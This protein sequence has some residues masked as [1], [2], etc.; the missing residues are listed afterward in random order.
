MTATNDF[1][2]FAVGGSANVVSQ[3]AYAALSALLTNGFQSGIANSQQLNKVWRQSSIMAAVLGT[4][5]QQSGQ[6]ATDDGTTSALVTNLKAA[7]MGSKVS[8]NAVTGAVTLT[9]AN[10]GQTQVLTGSPAYSV[11]LPLAS[12][13]ASGTVLSFINVG[14]AN[15]T[16]QRQGTTDTIKP[17]ATG[18]TSIVLTPGDTLEVECDGSGTWYAFDG[19][20]VLPYAGVMSG[21]NWNTPSAG[22]NSTRLATTAFVSALVGGTSAASSSISAN[23]YQKLPSGLIIQWGSVMVPNAGSFANVSFPIS[24]TISPYAVVG[25]MASNLGAT[26]AALFCQ[27]GSTNVSGFQI[28]QNIATGSNAAYWIAIGK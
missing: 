27:T 19:S 17:N 4:I 12:T 11:T 25:I 26:T 18:I 13:C 24:F 28:C 23:G 5:I 1:L 7:L 9:N 8:I 22:D 3:S 6:N 14:T 21:A 2:P 10:A 16:I 20:A 15:V